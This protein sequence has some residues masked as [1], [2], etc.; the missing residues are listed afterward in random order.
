[1]T[2]PGSEPEWLAVNR[3]NWDER[4][5]VHVASEFY[6]VPGFVEGATSLDEFEIDEI[7]ATVGGRTLVHLQCHFGLDT[8]SWARLGASVTGLDF[9]APAIAAAKELAGV[10]GVGARFVEGNVYDAPALLGE[11]YDVVY[12]GKGAINWLPDIEAWAHVLGDV[13]KPGG[14]VYVSEFH[15]FSWVF[16]DESLEVE[17]GYF[18]NTEPL[19]FDEQGTYTD[20]DAVLVHTRTLEWFH[21]IGDIVSALAEAGF[22]LEFLHEFA[23][24]HFQRWP[25]LK[26]IG[27]ARR[28]ELPDGMPP[29]PL[30]FSLLATKVA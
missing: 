17:Y 15:P 27:P 13:C 12:T 21:P 14:V 3:A 28:Y 9:S 26:R 29:L 22:R 20:P 30:M 19:R 24:T 23:H 16:A 25:F 1:M 5:P 18:H 10:V 6:D 2:D 7:G 8:L 11:Q 4:V